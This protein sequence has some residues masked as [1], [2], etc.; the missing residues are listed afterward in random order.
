MLIKLM[1]FPATLVTLHVI[2]FHDLNYYFLILFVSHGP[3][4]LDRMQTLLLQVLSLIAFL[5]VSGDCWTQVPSY[6]CYFSI[7]LF[8]ISQCK[9]LLHLFKSLRINKEMLFVS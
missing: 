8:V 9:Y 4:Q 2:P 3:W 6:Y 5:L 7:S 1:P